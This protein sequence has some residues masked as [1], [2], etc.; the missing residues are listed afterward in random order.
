M[1]R[2]GE[3]IRKRKDGRWE[4]RIKTENR[5]KSVYAGTYTD[6]KIKM[7][8]FRAG[9]AA[10]DPADLCT[11]KQAA[12]MWLTGKKEKVKVTSVEKYSYLLERHI[13]P[14]IGPVE[15]RSI[16]KSTLNAFAQKQL[17]KGSLNGEGGL[18]ASYI[19]TMLIIINS[20]LRFAS[21]MG[22]PITQDY[23]IRMP[24]AV[25]KQPK[26][27]TYS[28]RTRIEEQVFAEPDPTGLGILLA[29][30]LGLRIGEVCALSWEDIDLDNRILYV[31]HTVIRHRGDDGKPLQIAAPKSPWSV[32]EL[33]LQED[34][35]KL[36]KE[37]KA[38]SPSQYP[39]SEKASFIGPRTFEYRFHRALKRYGVE[40]TNFH[41]LRHTFA[42]RCIE[43]GIDPKTT[44][45][46]L[47]HANVNITLNTY[48]HTTMESKRK[49]M[50]KLIFK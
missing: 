36:L 17:V 25:K 48:V 24:K 45:E 21:E 37:I 39:V 41:T 49:Q 46:L 11:F 22:C 35:I 50:N 32:R 27:L 5:Y 16:D 38:N 12:E 47:G 14:Y 28:Q 15:V 34:L 29:L 44:S 42:S 1:S 3:N 23:K 31:R 26:I 4:G 33:P 6:V 8:E 9:A 10:P 30:R 7:R 20:V 19:Q 18:S 2:R 40:D 13:L 43:V